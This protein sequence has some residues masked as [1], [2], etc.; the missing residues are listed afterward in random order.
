[1]GLPS[2]WR[3]AALRIAPA[4]APR[5]RRLHM[6]FNPPSNSAGAPLKLFIVHLSAR[7]SIVALSV[8][9]IPRW[10]RGHGH[11]VLAA[12]Y[13]QMREIEPGRRAHIAAL[14]LPRSP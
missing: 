9:S 7:R 12:S 8:M 6:P 2:N 4:I 14:S 13:A 5:P 10:H 11:E 3:M 1:M